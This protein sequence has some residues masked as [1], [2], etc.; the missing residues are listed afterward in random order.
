MGNILSLPAGQPH[1]RSAEYIFRYP[2]PRVYLCSA[3]Q[4]RQHF[5]AVPSFT[6]LFSPAAPR[7]PHPAWHLGALSPLTPTAPLLCAAHARRF[8]FRTHAVAH[9]LLMTSWQAKGKWQS[10]WPT[11]WKGA[12]FSENENMIWEEA[13]SST[14]SLSKSCWAPSVSKCLHCPLS[15]PPTSFPDG[16]WQ[17]HHL[18]RRG[19]CMTG[20]G[21]RGEANRISR[22]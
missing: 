20:V 17:G 2:I 18:W 10:A 22:K 15:L 6:F 8:L 13:R 3:A 14:I 5:S 16:D 12:C 19:S 21:S 9:C 7:E 1:K 11:D 4:S